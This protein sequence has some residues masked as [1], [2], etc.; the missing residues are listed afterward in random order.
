MFDHV[1]IRVSDLGRS[2]RFYG[3]A[4]APLEVPDPVRGGH[5]VE[6]ND[7]SMAQAREDRP[8]T[9]RLHVAF[10]AP[11]RSRIDEWWE[12]LTAAGYRDDGA[13]GS[14]P[15][16]GR[17]YYG[18]FVLDP[19]GNSVE[20]V[21]NR[22]MRDDG[23]LIDHLWIRVRNEA[24]AR[25]FYET[26]A[27]VG[28]FEVRRLEG[29]TQ[30]VGGGATFSVIEGEPTE[31]VHLAFPAPDRETV[32][33]FHRVALAAGYR[34]NGAPGERPRYHAGYYG[35]FVLDPDGNNVEAV[36]HGRE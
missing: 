13:P 6:W 25:R 18:A 2:E 19:D 29:R 5:F 11:S 24:A 30:F 35:A 22:G 34:D 4:L 10:V 36:F 7:F 20:A 14:R 27:P 31:N 8:V 17:E 33:R 16:Y 28:G 32:G 1:T 15:Q 3:T 12:T 26:I 21:H 9:R 23:G